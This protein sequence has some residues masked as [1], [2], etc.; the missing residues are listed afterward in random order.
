MSNMQHESS[1]DVLTAHYL[2]GRSFGPLLSLGTMVRRGHVFDMRC[3]DFIHSSSAIL[4]LIFTF[5]FILLLCS[6]STTTLLILLLLLLLLLL[7]LRLLL[8]S[9]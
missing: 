6:I 2:G 4:M 9:V 7:I 1:E 5:T 8:H 3:D